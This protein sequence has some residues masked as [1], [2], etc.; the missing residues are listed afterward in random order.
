M[1]ESGIYGDY[2]LLLAHHVAE[3]AEEYT[4]LFSFRSATIIMDNS[5]VELG[6]PVDIDTMFKACMAV[7]HKVISSGGKYK[8]G[9]ELVVVLPDHY[10]DGA[11]TQLATLKALE[12]WPKVLKDLPFPYS[13][14]AIAQGSDI[15]EWVKCLEAFSEI[16]AIEWIG[17]PRNFRENLT[18]S[19]IQA[20]QLAHI[21]RPEWN[22][23]LFGFS[24]DLHDDIMT[25]S[26]A[27]SLGINVRGI[28]SAVPIRMALR[29]LQEIRFHYQIHTPRG[30]WWDNPGNYQKSEKT[31]KINMRRIRKWVG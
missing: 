14:M 9:T 5:V 18:G 24:D 6:E 8:Y 16:N 21:L 12:S 27:K 13:F 1:E 11:K 26:M 23:H 29:D 15:G 28:D 25:C 10:L 2:H 4:Q 31:L 22:Q 3:N 19:R 30:D 20:C 17:I 7:A